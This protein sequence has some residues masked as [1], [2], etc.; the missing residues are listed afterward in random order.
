MIKGRR[1]DVNFKKMMGQNKVF[2]HQITRRDKTE[3]KREHR[4]TASY[5]ETRLVPTSANS[6]I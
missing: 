4:L 6:H 5:E 1:C 2:D 3:Q